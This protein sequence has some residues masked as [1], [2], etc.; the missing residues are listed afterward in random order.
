MNNPLLTPF[1]TAPFSKIKNDHFSP[2]IQ[3]F[4]EKNQTEIDNY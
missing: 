2:A 3:H 4:I 1:D